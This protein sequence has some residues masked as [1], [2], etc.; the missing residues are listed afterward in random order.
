MIL[1]SPVLQ[2]RWLRAIVEAAIVCLLLVSTYR[3]AYR[4]LEAADAK[5]FIDWEL[6]SAV[7]FGCGYGLTQPSAPSPAVEAFVVRKSGSM[8]CRDFAWGGAPGEPIPIAFANRYSLYGAGWAIRWRGVSWATL[9]SYM[10]LLFA[11][12]MAFTYGL[13]RTAAGRTL[14]VLGVAAIACSV[15]VAEILTLRDFVKLRCFTAGWL[16]LAWLVRRGVSGGSGATL[17]PMAAA[18]AVM[19]TVIGFRMDALVFLP[20]F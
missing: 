1:R 2:S 13:F 17:L 7:M 18:G 16:A 8:T 5:T 19:G 3:L 10:A 9:D 14:S 12:S 4:F 6:K 20:V 11:L 15:T